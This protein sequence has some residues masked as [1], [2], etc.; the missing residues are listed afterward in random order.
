M[1]Q[2]K[3]SLLLGLGAVVSLAVVLLVWKVRSSGDDTTSAPATTATQTGAPKPVRPAPPRTSGPAATAGGPEAAD[4][5]GETKGY[6]EYTTA[7]GKL[8]RDHRSGNPSPVKFAGGDHP[9]NGPRIKAT[10][11]RAVSDQVRAIIKACAADVPP[12]AR[13][14]K[15]RAEGKVT[16]SIASGHVTVSKAIFELTAVVGAAAE[17]TKA[18]IE[19]KVAAVTAD[20]TDE[21]DVTDYALSMNYSIL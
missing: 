7:D 18:C 9:P 19:S 1:A 2:G 13:G 6:R 16:I 17:P 8:V 3:K 21:A 11:T 14:E 10:T 15:P 20:V 4:G 5:S 12:E